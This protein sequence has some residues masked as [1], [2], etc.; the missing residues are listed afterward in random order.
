MLFFFFS[1]THAAENDIL[2]VIGNQGGLQGNPELREKVVRTHQHSIQK[3]IPLSFE[4]KSPFIFRAYK[5]F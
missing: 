1:S 2:R 3:K 4:K 5:S